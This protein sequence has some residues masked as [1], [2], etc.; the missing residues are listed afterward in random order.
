MKNNEKQQNKIQYAITLIAML[1][2]CIA[3]FLYKLVQLIISFF[4]NSIFTTII[5]STIILLGSCQTDIEETRTPAFK[6]TSFHKELVNGVYQCTA[7]IKVINIAKRFL[8]PYF[9]K[10]E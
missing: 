10:L 6:L 4:K 1:S 3:P 2:L 7:T 9:N 8:T 5:I